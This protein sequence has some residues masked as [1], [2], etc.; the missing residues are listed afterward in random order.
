MPSRRRFSLLASILATAGL[1]FSLAGCPDP[2]GA[3]EDFATRYEDNHKTT[4]TGTGGSGGGEACTPATEG[5]LDGEYMFSLSAR[6]SPKKAFALDT[7]MTTH[8]DGAG[9]LTV[10][11]DL[12]PLSKDDQ[13][14][15]VGTVLS[16]T[17]LP[18]A[19]DG[20]FTWDLG[21][22]TLPGAA[23][24]IT[25]ADVVTTL[26]LAGDLC[27]GDRAGFVCGDVTGQVTEPLMA[28]LS[29]GSAFTMQAAVGGSLPSPVINCAKDPA[30]Y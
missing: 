13:T 28:D 12:Q 22:V 23:N 5:E 17:A 3:F 20:S 4:S 7:T 8:D 26:Q 15:P 2:E 10:D 11:L 21:M 6:L 24:P 14:T 27:G 16:F 30:V 9:G 29:P 18:V 25:G 1:N 19:A